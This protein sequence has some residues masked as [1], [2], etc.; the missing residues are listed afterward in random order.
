MDDTYTIDTSEGGRIINGDFRDLPPDIDAGS[1]DLILTD[2]PYGTVKGLGD[3]DEIQ[4][5]MKGKTEWDTAVPAADIFD[6]SE[7]L[8]R[9]SGKLILFSQEPYTSELITSAKTNLPF[10]YRMMW[11]KDHFANSLIAKDSPVNLYEDIILFTKEY[12]GSQNY[13]L[14]DYADAVQS[15]IGLSLNEINNRLGH[16][17][18]EH[19]FYIESTQFE[20]CT[21]ET[22]QQLIAEFGIDKMPGFK[23]YSELEEM[24][25]ENTFNLPNGEKYKSNVFEY[26]KPQSNY[27]P[28][29]KPV[30]LLEDLIRTYTHEGDR[31]V[32]LTAGSASTAVAAVNTG[33]ECIAVEKDP[34]YYETA[35]DRVS[36]IDDSAV[37]TSGQYNLEAY[38]DGGTP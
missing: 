6:V 14:R 20:L 35:V 3:S 4:H 16:R 18:A 1:V 33:R 19:F 36:R 10:S 38:A 28:T 24:R 32:D 27:H 29:Q 31:V 8:L 26:A 9:K 22:Y 7:Q 17:K 21:R 25:A 37:S 13:P 2:P 23:P 5:G 34:D 30:P 12:D 11:V 15:S